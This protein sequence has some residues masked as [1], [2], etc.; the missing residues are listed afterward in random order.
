[1]LRRQSTLTP[2]QR[3]LN[4]R[5]AF[6]VSPG[7]AIRDARILLVDDVLTTGATL[8]AGALALVKAGCREVSIGVIAAA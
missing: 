7:F 5:R 2:P 1:M 3:R 6:R 4:V 8:E